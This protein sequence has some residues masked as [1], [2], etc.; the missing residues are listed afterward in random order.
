MNP[1]PTLN[2]IKIQKLKT[3]MANKNAKSTLPF[4]LRVT[5]LGVLPGKDG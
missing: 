2:Q 5:R 4:S 1:I 3:K